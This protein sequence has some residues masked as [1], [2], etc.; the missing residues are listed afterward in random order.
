MHEMFM[1][2]KPN[3]HCQR[4]AFSVAEDLVKVLGSQ[5]VSQRGL[6]KKARSENYEL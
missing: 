3:L 1:G 2:V 5:N 4:D 6:S